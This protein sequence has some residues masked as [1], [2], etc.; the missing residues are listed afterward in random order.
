M[1]RECVF[2]PW[3]QHLTDEQ[4]E[5]CQGDYYGCEICRNKKRCIQL[6]GK[7]IE[8]NIEPQKQK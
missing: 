3:A 2:E 5:V 6:I 4:I 8:K 7:E 1:K